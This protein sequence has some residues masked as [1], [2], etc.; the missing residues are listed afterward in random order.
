MS[1]E[2]MRYRDFI[3]AIGSMEIPFGSGE[4][5]KFKEDWLSRHREAMAYWEHFQA[6][7][8]LR[9]FQCLFENYEATNEPQLKAVDSLKEYAANA[10]DNLRNGKNIIL[11]GPK[12][13]GKDHLLVATCRE[14]FYQCGAIIHWEQGIDLFR[15][16][17]SGQ[18]DYIQNSSC[19][20]RPEMTADFLYVSDLLPPTGVL[21]ERQQAELFRLVDHRYSHMKPTLITLNVSSSEEAE[22]RIGSQAVDRLRDN[23]LVIHT[24]WDSKR[25]NKREVLV[26]DETINNWKA[27]E[28]HAKRVNLSLEMIFC[29]RTKPG[30]RIIP[31]ALESERVVQ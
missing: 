10:D 6:K 28:G 30:P 18:R 15:A 19:D 16:I 26:P 20:T 29:K 9:Y 4:W 7:R 12:G 13:S 23:A 24:N 3:Q 8:G 17:P 27:I 22:R 25:S 5:C 21:N 2:Q 1:S 11:F 14:I 31:S